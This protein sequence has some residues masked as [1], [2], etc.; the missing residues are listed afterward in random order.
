MRGGEN[1]MILVKT[2]LPTEFNY[3]I[4]AVTYKVAAFFDAEKPPLQD[5]LKR[6]LTSDIKNKSNRTFADGQGGDVK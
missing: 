2:P 4:G 5:K 3:K 6:L 1:V